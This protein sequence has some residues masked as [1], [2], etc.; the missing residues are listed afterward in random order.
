[1][2]LPLGLYLSLNGY[3]CVGG[4][5]LSSCYSFGDPN[6]TVYPNSHACCS[7]NCP[8]RNYYRRDL[9]SDLNDWGLPGD[10][11]FG[12]YSIHSG[13]KYLYRAQGPLPCPYGW[14]QNFK[15]SE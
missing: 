6:Q 11:P 9:R 12:N 3:I 10:R 15:V 5:K 14:C 2:M 1:M 8:H 7:L 4:G 13:L